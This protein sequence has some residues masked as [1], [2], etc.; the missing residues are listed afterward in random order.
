MFLRSIVILA[1]ILPY[2]FFFA[3]CKEKVT[4]Y[5]MVSGVGDYFFPE[6]RLFQNKESTLI[7][8]GL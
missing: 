8:E 1:T 2:I 7:K 4:P 5:N 3:K 6:L